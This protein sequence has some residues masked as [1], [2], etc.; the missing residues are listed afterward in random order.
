M[1]PCRELLLLNDPTKAAMEIA[2]SVIARPSLLDFARHHGLTVPY[3]SENFILPLSWSD[4]SDD[5]A[6]LSELNLSSS[7]LA[8]SKYDLLHER[9]AVSSQAV[10]LLAKACLPPEA[11]DN[12]AYG[13]E[14][15]RTCAQM[16]QELPLLRSDNDLDLRHF[17]QRVE[18][19]MRTINL[20]A[21]VVDDE[22]DEGLRW[23]SRLQSLPA[24][25]D[26]QMTTER[27]RVGGQAAQFLHD[28][29]IT[30]SKEPVAVD[31]SRIGVN[32]SIA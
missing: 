23:P 3:T 14:A 30:L 21:I 22:A 9:L 5:D 28:T 27:L 11:L 17:G 19:D 26:T 12:A 7:S 15:K 18:P 2:A 32:S 6:F 1:V 8:R 10:L 4:T 13:E 29:L 31:E 20:R 24:E 25:I 16:K